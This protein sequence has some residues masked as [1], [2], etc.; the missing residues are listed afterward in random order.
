MP[1]HAEE[2]RATWKVL[3]PWDRSARVL[4]LGVGPYVLQ[5]L[6]RTYDR[7]DTVRSDARSAEQAEPLR[8]CMCDVGSLADLATHAPSFA[9][10]VVIV[11][12]GA[13]AEQLVSVCGACNV[14]KR[15]TVAGIPAGQPRIFLNLA[16][17]RS[18]RAGL[19]MHTAGSWLARK[20]VKLA[21]LLSDLGFTGHL[22][23][24]CATFFTKEAYMPELIRR[25][26]E[27]FHETVATCALYAG[28]VDMKRK[29]TV[30]LTLKSGRQLMMK[31]ADTDAGQQAIRRET[32][33]L[34]TLS[35]TALGKRNC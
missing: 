29:I 3:L 30:A 5:S 2:R 33:V 16:D 11:V 1:Y 8:I 26:E 15:L 17:R 4:A 19:R 9:D 14:S 6:R 25:T 7:V 20:K 35:A 18:R 32:A 12:L 22:D 28:S 31:L 23:A 34:Q 13:R 10:D 27:A 24:F 21:S